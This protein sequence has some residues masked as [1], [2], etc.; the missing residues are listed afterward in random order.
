VPAWGRQGQ[1]F[2]NFVEIIREKEYT[3]CEKAG[4]LAVILRKE[5]SL[6]KRKEF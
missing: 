1:E 3:F 4:H 5:S 6:W 2:Y